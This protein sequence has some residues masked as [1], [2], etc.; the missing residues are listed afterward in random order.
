MN[1]WLRRIRLSAQ[2][3]ICRR[4]GGGSRSVHCHDWKG[5]QESWCP[6]N[7]CPDGS[8]HQ[9]RRHS[10]RP[11]RRWKRRAS[12]SWSGSI[13]A[14]KPVIVS[15]HTYH[16]SYFT[17]SILFIYSFFCGVSH[18]GRSAAKFPFWRTVDI[19]K[20]RNQYWNNVS[21]NI[22]YLI[23]FV[24]MMMPPRCK[25]PVCSGAGFLSVNFLQDFLYP[26]SLT[27]QKHYFVQ[28]NCFVLPHGIPCWHPS[29]SPKQKNPDCQ[30]FVCSSLCILPLTAGKT[31]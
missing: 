29:T 24:G 16:H 21:Q 6:Q 9:E 25:K 5:R 3:C 27:E 30:R 11:C 2:G 8:R 13:Y 15:V 4:T 17:Q 18:A 20:Q 7:V 19:H 26:C 31:I 23:L 28:L 14:G 1:Q 10:H 22:P 12:S